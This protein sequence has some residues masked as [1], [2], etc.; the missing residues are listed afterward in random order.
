LA[1]C[2][3][4]R[5]AD[6]KPPNAEWA[7]TKRLRFACASPFVLFVTACSTELLLLM[8]ETPN[9]SLRDE[10]VKYAGQLQENRDQADP[11]GR[12]LRFQFL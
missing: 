11:D 12:D 2:L 1:R 9:G 6:S 8:A 7:K 5:K 4:S 3:K 10:T